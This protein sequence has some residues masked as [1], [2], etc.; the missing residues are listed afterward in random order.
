MQDMILILLIYSVQWFGP[1]IP[2]WTT[3]YITATVHNHKSLF[4]L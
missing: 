1:A 4:M 3:Y 2:H